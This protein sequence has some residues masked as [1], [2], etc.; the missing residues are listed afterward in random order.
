MLFRSLLLAGIAHAGIDMSDGVLADLGHL[1]R[2]SRVGADLDIDALPSS[3]PLLRSFD[4]ATRRA[5][6][7]SGGDDYELCFTAPKTAR[8]A[9]E[10]AMHTID[11][12]ATRIGRI[13]G[14][15][16]KIALKDRDGTEW[17]SPRAG[18]VHFES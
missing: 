15:A 10:D 8:L 1:C 14:D 3:E 11:L 2:A 6:Q 13:N 12:P 7:T 17:L 18:Y 16:G 9:V 5:L 4:I